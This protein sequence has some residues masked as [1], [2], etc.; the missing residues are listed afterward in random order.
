MEFIIKGSNFSEWGEEYLDFL[1][2]FK[3]PEKTVNH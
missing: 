1:K 3:N 2:F